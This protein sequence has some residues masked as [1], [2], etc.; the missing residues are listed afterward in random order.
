MKP[1]KGFIGKLGKW[2]EIGHRN[3]SRHSI[4]RFVRFFSSFYLWYICQVTTVRPMVL[5]LF[6]V[7]NGRYNPFSFLVCMY[8]TIYLLSRF[9]VN[10]FLDKFFYNSSD[11]PRYLQ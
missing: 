3:Y 9:K 11:R 1:K 7:R 2:F 4:G 5:R 10:W 6:D 8:F